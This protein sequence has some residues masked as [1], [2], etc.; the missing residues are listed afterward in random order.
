MNIVGAIGKYSLGVF[1]RASDFA[2][3]LTLLVSARVSVAH[4]ARRRI[5]YKLYRREIYYTGI[6]SLPVNAVVA[7]LVGTLLVYRLPPLS[8]GEQLVPA[9]AELF[10]R[11]IIREV[12]PLVCAVLLIVRSGTAVTSKIA[13][14]KLFREFEV[15]KNMGI[16]PLHLVLV[17]AFFAF[18]V[19]ILLMV[20]YFVFFSMASAYFTLWV[21]EH[22]LEPMLLMSNILLRL[23]S[24]DVLVTVVQCLASA[25]I[26][27]LYSIHYGS[28]MQGNLTHLARSMSTATT[29]QFVLVFVVN[30]V[31]SI[32]AY[33]R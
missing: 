22:T 12:A 26:V 11:V 3:L 10:V 18:P 23:T 21:N 4:P 28:H 24:Y 8:Q 29:R 19:S 5:L 13:Y 30:V 9:F 6:Q 1:Q 15:M 33:A 27:G 2:A 14:L 32:L 17:P 25:L 20:G 7:M 16:N 31:V